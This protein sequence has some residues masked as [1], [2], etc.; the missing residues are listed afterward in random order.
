MNVRVNGRDTEMDER[1]TVADVVASFGG[2]GARIGV[3]VARNGEVVTR[4]QWPTTNLSDGDRVEIL[5][6]LQGG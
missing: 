3:A 6:A 1:A 4:S 2:A 5:G